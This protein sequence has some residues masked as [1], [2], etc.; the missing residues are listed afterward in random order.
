MWLAHKKAR[1]Q[2]RVPVVC[3]P[4]ECVRGINE[5]G[6]PRATIRGIRRL[7]RQVSQR[8]P[9]DARNAAMALA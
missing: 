1:Y 4:S 7:L 5:R 8:V 6:M 2:D 9:M 3:Q